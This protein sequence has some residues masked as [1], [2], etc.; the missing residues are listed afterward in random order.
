M[1]PFGGWSGQETEASRVLARDT[2]DRTSSRLASTPGLSSMTTSH[3]AGGAVDTAARRHVEIPI[4]E[5]AAETFGF[6]DLGYEDQSP[7]I[8]VASI[9]AG[10]SIF[11][12]LV[13]QIRQKQLDKC[14]WCRRCDAH[15][16]F[17]LSSPSFSAIRTSFRSP[18]I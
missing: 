1:L 13:L 18:V 12:L 4:D 8:A 10:C 2:H 6:R 3:P 16:P 14:P 17:R 5:S 15:S 9:V 11:R 7:F